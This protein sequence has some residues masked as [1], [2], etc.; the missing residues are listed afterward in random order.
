MSIYTAYALYAEYLLKCTAEGI[1]A[2]SFW[3]WF[4]NEGR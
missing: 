2:K 4:V 1:E 3:Q